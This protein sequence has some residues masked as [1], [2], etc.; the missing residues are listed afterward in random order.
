MTF[1]KKKMD[2]EKFRMIK[3]FRLGKYHHDFD[4]IWPLPGINYFQYEI[5]L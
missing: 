5:A 2:Q 3:G 1:V 4:K